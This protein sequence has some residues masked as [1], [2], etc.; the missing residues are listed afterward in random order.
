MKMED[1]IIIRGA[2]ENNLKDIF[3]NL[4]GI[5]NS[6]IPSFFYQIGL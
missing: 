4:K 3:L 1:K 5:S 6:E 2:K